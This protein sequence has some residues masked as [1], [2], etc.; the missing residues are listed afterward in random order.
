M[1]PDTEPHQDKLDNNSQIDTQVESIKCFEH[2][3]CKLCGGTPIQIN[4]FLFEV[5][6]QFV[7]VKLIDIPEKCTNYWLE[8]LLRWHRDVEV[9]TAILCLVELGIKYSAYVIV[10]AGNRVRC[11]L[12]SLGRDLFEN[13]QSFVGTFVG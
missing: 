2:Y 8:I 11:K 9:Q 4:L 3:K 1:N 5:E 6:P 12:D 7:M 10:F 13:R